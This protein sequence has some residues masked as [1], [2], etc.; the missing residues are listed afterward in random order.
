M[1]NAQP[2]SL[3]F[4]PH[5]LGIHGWSSPKMLKKN[6]G[7]QKK[8]VIAPGPRF[9]IHILLQVSM[10]NHPAIGVS[11]WFSDVFP[12]V[13]GTSFKRFIRGRWCRGTP[14]SP[15]KIV[16]ALLS[17]EGFQGGGLSGAALRSGTNRS[18]ILTFIYV[19]IYIWIIYDYH[20]F[21]GL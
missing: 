13:W 20:I 2:S 17:R 21:V 7:V 4:L 18:G 15:L 9:I 10:I 8:F 12:M 5:F 11:L 3:L 6:A 1:L 19:Y 16:R 14:P